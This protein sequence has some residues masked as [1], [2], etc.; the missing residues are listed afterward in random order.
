M[1]CLWFLIAQNTY[2]DPQLNFFSSNLAVVRNHTKL[3]SSNKGAGCLTII[4]A[5]LRVNLP[6]GVAVQIHVSSWSFY[7]CRKASCL[8]V[9]ISVRAKESIGWTW[10][11]PIWELF[12]AVILHARSPNWC[13]VTTLQ[14]LLILAAWLMSCMLLMPSPP[15]DFGL[16]A[17]QLQACIWRFQRKEAHKL[18]NCLQTETGK[19]WHYIQYAIMPWITDL[20][21]STL[22]GSDRLYLLHPS[23]LFLYLSIREEKCLGFK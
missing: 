2:L 11:S 4:Q 16:I 6:V 18:S 15:S 9:G 21:S 10:A 14:T 23:S 19:W 8:A 7:M 1:D 22:P 12:Y 17:D 3:L 5:Q 13:S 20:I